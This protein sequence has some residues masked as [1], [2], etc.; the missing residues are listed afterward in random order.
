[1]KYFGLFEEKQDLIDEIY[2]SEVSV[3]YRKAEYDIWL[4][5]NGY[6]IGMTSFDCKGITDKEHEDSIQSFETPELL[7]ENAVFYDGTKFS[8]AAEMDHTEID[9]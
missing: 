8:D 1:M 4:D 5:A 2:A 6:C 7:Y 9:E 3:D